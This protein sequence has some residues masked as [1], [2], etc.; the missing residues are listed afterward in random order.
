MGLVDHALSIQ[1]V[2]LEELLLNRLF[3]VG[4]LPGFASA[5]VDVLCVLL[6]ELWDFEFAVGTL[7]RSHRAILYVFLHHLPVAL[8]VLAVL[9]IRLEGLSIEDLLSDG[10]RNRA[11]LSGTLTSSGH[12]LCT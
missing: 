5:I 11:D 1:N 7:H 10:S 9:A 12:T 6:V 4:A 2:G 8:E 3:A